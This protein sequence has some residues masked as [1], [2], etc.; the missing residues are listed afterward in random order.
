MLCEPSNGLPM[1]IANQIF[2]MTPRSRNC[3]SMAILFVSIRVPHGTTE[4][5][6]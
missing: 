6:D 4:C 1:Q 2:A 3:G 5:V